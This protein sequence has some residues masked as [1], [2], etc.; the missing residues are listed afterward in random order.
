MNS[1]DSNKKCPKLNK[2]MVS[3]SKYEIFKFGGQSLK[4]EERGMQLM[5]Q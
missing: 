4:N 5:M 2:F 3:P 1:A